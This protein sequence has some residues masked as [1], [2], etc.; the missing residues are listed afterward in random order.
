MRWRVIA[1]MAAGGVAA[2]GLFGAALAAGVSPVM[3][4]R[5]AASRAA[6]RLAAAANTHHNHRTLRGDY[7]LH[8]QAPR[9][10]KIPL[11]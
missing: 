1:V 2:V 3:G 7:A 5:I 9:L 6:L 10:A 4:R 11:E 8:P